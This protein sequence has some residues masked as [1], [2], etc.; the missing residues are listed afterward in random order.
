MDPLSQAAVGVAF[1]QTIIPKN[2]LIIGTFIA[3]VAALAPDLD[4]LIKSNDDPL[5][6][7]K[8]H[9]H[10]THSL[11]FI[12]LGAL[13]VSAGIYPFAKKKISFKKIFKICLISYGTHGLLDACTSYG[14]MLMWPLSDA[15]T[16]WSVISIIDPIFT[17]CIV[18]FICLHIVKKVRIL[19]LLCL[20]FIT[21]YLSLGLIQKYRAEKAIENVVH[22]RGHKPSHITVKPSIGNLLVWKTVYAEKGFFYIDAVRLT[23]NK[24]LC[25][26]T[27]IEEFKKIKHLPNLSEDSQ[28]AKDIERFRWFSN[29]HL[30]Y[31]PEDNYIVDVRYSIL[32]NTI[33]P[34]WGIVVEENMKLKEHASWKTN[35]DSRKG[36]F[37]E[38]IL[39]LKG[40]NCFKIS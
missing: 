30:G 25:E 27:S 21:L 7:L 40:E 28:Q 35:R 9:R 5:L 29:N 37:N 18:G 34:L 36:N 4:V 11:A 10:F 31:I 14:T 6:G 16:A 33:D 38:F 17:T 23:K 15:R 39:L 13:I 12:P 24:F 26:G 1:A 2:K 3:L 20:G 8:Y 32:P 19:G 22:L